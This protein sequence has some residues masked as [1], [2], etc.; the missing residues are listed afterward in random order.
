M[1]PAALED[2]PRA[3]MHAQHGPHYPPR[4]QQGQDASAS[5]GQHPLLRHV[6]F[7]KRL[8]ACVCCIRSLPSLCGVDRCALLRQRWRCVRL[9]YCGSPSFVGHAAF[10]DVLCAVAAGLLHA[11]T[12]RGC[13]R[14]YAPA[15]L[16]VQLCLVGA[17]LLGDACLRETFL[18]S[19]ATPAQHS[20]MWGVSA[21]RRSLLL[22]LS[23]ITV[24][25]RCSWRRA[26]PSCRDAVCMCWRRVPHTPR[27]CSCVRCRC[28]CHACV[29]MCACLCCLCPLPALLLVRGCGFYLNPHECVCISVCIGPWHC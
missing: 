15:L 6:A 20:L 29:A 17:L 25:C 18:H 7:I 5:S 28:A 13:R 14:Q 10:V 23:L 4:N 12:K 21:C 16:S 22:T 9:S 1:R 19:L 2:A 8:A 27:F 24:P 11:L 3:A 26:V